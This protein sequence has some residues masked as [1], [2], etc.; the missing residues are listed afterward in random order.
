MMTIA[1]WSVFIVALLPYV[2]T[3]TAK[4]SRSGY[5]NNKPRVFLSEL[6]GRGARANWAQ[7]NAFEAFPAFA[8]AVIIAS[9][10]AKINASTLDTLAIIF[11][12]C[13]LLHGVFYVM[14]KAVLRSLVWMIGM[15]SWVSML[16]LSL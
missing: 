7:Q 6:S 13:R 12:V 11:V 4:A 1:Y 16:M 8:A 10:I 14:D 5:D 3:I 2:W 9:Q 15:G